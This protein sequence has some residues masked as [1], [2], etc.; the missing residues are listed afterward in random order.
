MRLAAVLLPGCGEGIAVPEPMDMARIVRPMYG[1][2]P[3]ALYA[4]MVVCSR[5]VY[6]SSDFG[7]NRARVTRWLAA[8]DA[9]L[10]STGARS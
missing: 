6:G 5:S 4:A 10:A 3:A 8:L 1:V 2:P 9:G 7:V